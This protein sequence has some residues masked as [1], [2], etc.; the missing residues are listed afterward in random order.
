[1]EY[2]LDELEDVQKHLK[3]IRKPNDMDMVL[4]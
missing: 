3:N 4:A 2:Y 1:M